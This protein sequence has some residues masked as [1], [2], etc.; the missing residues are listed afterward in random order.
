MKFIFI[1]I[2]IIFIYFI[3]FSFSYSIE[4]PNIKNLIIYEEKQK[5]KFFDF[6]NE[7]GN[8]VNLK[9]FKSELIILNFW[10]TWCAPCREEMPS[11][12]NLQL[13]NDERKIKIIPINIGGENIK[14]SKIFFDA[15]L[16]DELKIF[17]GD[18]AGIAKNL[19]L[20]GL[21]TTIFI[22][23]DGYEFAR[24]VGSID[25]NS[26]EFLNWLNKLN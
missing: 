2:K 5:I 10:A 16:I 4:A 23:K 8:K 6:L 12:N 22:D 13:L 18:G 21:P 1:F 26:K 14:T 9:D 25:F 3:P 20:R 7:A 17:V 24:I 11:L 15:L 19:K